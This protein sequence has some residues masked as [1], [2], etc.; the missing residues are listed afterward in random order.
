MGWAE[1]GE[2]AGPTKSRGRG[3]EC[4]RG[5]LCGPGLV[6]ARQVRGPAVAE[7]EAKLHPTGKKL[8]RLGPVHSD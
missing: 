7:P 5:G 4:E 6:E 2:S 1:A 3:E 8:P